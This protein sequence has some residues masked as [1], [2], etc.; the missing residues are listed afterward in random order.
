MG[1]IISILYYAGGIFFWPIAL[2]FVKDKDLKHRLFRVFAVTS[3]ILLVLVGIIFIVYRFSLLDY[4]WMPIFL[5]FPLTNLI[6]ICISVGLSRR[7]CKTACE[8]HNLK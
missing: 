6:S 1:T 2:F 4:N 8:M 7:S 3:L 5:L